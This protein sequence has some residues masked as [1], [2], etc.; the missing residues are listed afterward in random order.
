VTILRISLRSRV[1]F[2]DI[3]LLPYGIG[4]MA[5]RILIIRTYCDT[6]LRTCVGEKKVVVAVEPKKEGPLT[7]E[8]CEEAANCYVTN[9]FSP[10]PH[11]ASLCVRP[12]KY[13]LSDIEGSLMLLNWGSTM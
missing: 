2:L 6:D 10:H 3:S 5:Q 7:R 9:Y 13:R 4:S 12:R 11:A 1:I 8:S